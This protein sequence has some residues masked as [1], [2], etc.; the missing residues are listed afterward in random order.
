MKNMYEFT[1]KRQYVGKIADESAKYQIKSPQSVKEYLRNLEFYMDDQENMI[2]LLL[3]TRNV[4]K[5]FHVVTRGLLDR[6]HTHPR[7]IFKAAIISGASKIILSHN[8]P[9]GDV[10]PSKQDISSTR[11]I[12]DAGDIIGIKVIDHIITGEHLGEFTSLSMRASGSMN[13]T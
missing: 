13:W 9:S 11:N 5:G 7:E 8:H 10:T 2:V 6:S 1:V 3:D 4:I 12:I